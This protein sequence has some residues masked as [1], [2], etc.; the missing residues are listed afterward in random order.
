MPLKQE[1]FLLADLRSDLAIA[2]GV[3]NTL[4]QDSSGWVAHNTDVF[5]ISQ[6]IKSRAVANEVVVLGPFLSTL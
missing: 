6:S 3:A 5:G 2:T 1:A 4:V